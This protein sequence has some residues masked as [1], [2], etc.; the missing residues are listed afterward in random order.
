MKPLADEPVRQVIGVVANTRAAGLVRGARPY[1][2][3]PQAQLPDALSVFNVTQ[4]PMAWVVR[5]R[6]DPS[7]AAAAV[8]DELRAATGLPVTNVQ[9]LSDIA[10]ASV[11]R[12]RLNMLLMSVFGGVAL[13]LAAIGLYG[14]VAHSVEQRTH[15]IGVRLALGADTTEVRSMVLR[16]GVP[17]IVT[18]VGAGLIAAFFLAKLL[19]AALYGVEPHDALVFIGVPVVLAAVA[20]FAGAVAAQRATRVKPIAALRYE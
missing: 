19:A 16:Q 10:S 2:Y 11:S 14:L 15:E 13:L 20:L 8:R 12:Q 17:L 7:G 5:T 4:T 6:G 18:G 1:A 3:V 9:P